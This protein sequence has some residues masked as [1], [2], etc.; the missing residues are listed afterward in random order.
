[1]NLNIKQKDCQFYV[2]IPHRKVVCVYTGAKHL[3][4]D[5][6]SNGLSCAFL[7]DIPTK[8]LERLKMPNTFSGIATCSPEDEFD[9]DYGRLLAFNKMKYKLNSSFFKRANLFVNTLDREIDRI[10][11]EIDKVGEGLTNGHNRR[12]EKLKARYAVEAD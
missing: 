10:A 6:I 5:Y 8:V 12:E 9:E 2:D 4:Y 3:L 11:T 1:M 7:Y